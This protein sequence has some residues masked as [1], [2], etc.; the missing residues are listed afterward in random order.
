MVEQRPAM[1]RTMGPRV[2]DVTVTMT[3]KDIVAIL[4]R[5]ILL[6]VSIT[7][8]GVIIGV[9]GWYLFLKFRLRLPRTRVHN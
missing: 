1:N 5:H 6:I 4:R 8:L 9:V 2:P 3:P 7:I